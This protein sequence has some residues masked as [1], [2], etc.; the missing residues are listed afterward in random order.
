MFIAKTIFDKLSKT[1][2]DISMKGYIQKIVM[3]KF[4]FLMFCEKQV[5][6]FYRLKIL[7]HLDQFCELVNF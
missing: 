5:S 4:G 6:I 2:Q 3:D 1:D 7:K